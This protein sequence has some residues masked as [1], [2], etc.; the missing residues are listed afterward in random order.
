MNP[1]T[2]KMCLAAVSMA[3]AAVA[4]A[5]T[6]TPIDVPGAISTNPSGI[7]SSGEIVGSYTDASNIEHGFRLDRGV[8]VA[9]DYPGALNTTPISIN[10][11]GD[12][13]GFFLDS[14][15]HW[16]GFMLSEGTYF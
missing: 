10:N 9:I 14:S 8:F 4:L 11:S 16:H 5:D 3:I 15:S 7:N 12:V 13:A 1:T 2:I 6:Y